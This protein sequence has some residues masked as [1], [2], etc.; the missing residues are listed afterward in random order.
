MNHFNFNCNYVQL[1]Y[2]LNPLLNIINSGPVVKLP[3]TSDFELHIIPEDRYGIPPF[4]VKGS[5]S[6]FRI[7]ET[8]SIS[9]SEAFGCI[10]APKLLET[11]IDPV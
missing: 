9:F 2:I 10:A 8:I 11:S 1:F 5:T 3:T 6:T 4:I 7:E